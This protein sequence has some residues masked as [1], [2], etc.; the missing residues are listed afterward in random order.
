MQRWLFLSCSRATLSLSLNL[1]HRPKSKPTSFASAE[2]FYAK[3][4]EYSRMIYS[5]IK[6][7][8]SVRVLGIGRDTAPVS[9]LAFS[10]P[11]FTASCLP[12]HTHTFLLF[13]CLFCALGNYICPDACIG[14]SRD[15]APCFSSERKILFHWNNQQEAFRFPTLVCHLSKKG[16]RVFRVKRVES[17]QAE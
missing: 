4:N 1:M 7:A 5:N 6:R 15:V 12:T 11:R 9:L 10:S 3:I 8:S 2:Y 14:V 13:R 17:N 16:K